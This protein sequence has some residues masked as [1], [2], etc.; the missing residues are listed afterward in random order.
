MSRKIDNTKY[1][2][3]VATSYAEPD[4]MHK[5]VGEDWNSALSSDEPL[6]LSQRTK[7]LMQ[8]ISATRKMRVELRTNSI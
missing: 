4:T 7:D 8:R 2:R 5:T 1:F 3:I 6:V